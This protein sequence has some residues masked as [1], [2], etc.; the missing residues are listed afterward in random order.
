MSV[1]RIPS[2]TSQTAKSTFFPR[3]AYVFV[4]FYGLFSLAASHVHKSVRSISVYPQKTDS[5]FLATPE[6]RTD[7]DADLYL[8]QP[9]QSNPWHTGSREETI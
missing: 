8:H 9:P 2:S 7:R 4:I 1:G 3:I 6:D 5:H